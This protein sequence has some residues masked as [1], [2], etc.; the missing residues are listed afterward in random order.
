L[1]SENES[2]GRKIPKYS[3]LIELI[4]KRGAMHLAV[5]CRQFRAWIQC[6]LFCHD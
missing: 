5:V 3:L 2:D 4:M 1:K 6:S